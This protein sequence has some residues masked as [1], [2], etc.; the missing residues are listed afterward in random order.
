MFR[1]KNP[2]PTDSE[3]ADRKQ[4]KSQHLH[5]SAMK[6]VSVI[7]SEKTPKMIRKPPKTEHTMLKLST[8][9]LG[10]AATLGLPSLDS[11]SQ[12]RIPLK[13]TEWRES[14]SKKSSR[15]SVPSSKH[16]AVCRSALR[17]EKKRVKRE[18]KGDSTTPTVCMI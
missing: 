9:S 5:A 12:S 16:Y 18:R 17:E 11:F 1:M 2:E 4:L 13:I 8:A 14:S 10:I 6:N 7:S 3:I 15:G